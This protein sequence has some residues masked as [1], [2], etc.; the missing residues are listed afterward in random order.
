MIIRQHVEFTMVTVE[1]GMVGTVVGGSPSPGFRIGFRPGM[2]I[3]VDA[4][5]GEEATSRSSI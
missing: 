3:M 1:V 4:I 5:G 2:T